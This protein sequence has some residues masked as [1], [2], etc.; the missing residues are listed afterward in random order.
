MAP[1]AGGHSHCRDRLS[2]GGTG[3]RGAVCPLVVDFDTRQTRF[4]KFFFWKFNI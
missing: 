1:S 4:Q 2:L 3:G